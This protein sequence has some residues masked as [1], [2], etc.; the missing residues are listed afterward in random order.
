[1]NVLAF[2]QAT[3]ERALSTGIPGMFIPTTVTLRWAE[4]ND[5]VPSVDPT[6]GAVIGSVIQRSEVVKGSVHYIAPTTSD[7][8]L[9]AELAVGDALLDLPA[10]VVITGRAE[11][12]F[13]ID[14]KRWVQKKVSDKLMDYW[15]HLIGDTRLYRTVALR[16]A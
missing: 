10:N 1:M 15:D 3:I 9:F 16:L 12:Y 8:R 7:V 6:T 14:G 11:L 4:S 2:A 5:P 13:E